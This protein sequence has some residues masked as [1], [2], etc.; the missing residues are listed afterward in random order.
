MARLAR[1]G[2]GKKV[3]TIA[4]LTAALTAAG[5]IVAAPASAG[6]S[7]PVG[8]HCVFYSDFSSAKHEYFV[9]DND[10][11]NDYFNKGGAS[12]KGSLVNNNVWA[13]SNST[14]TDYYSLYYYSPY[15]Y[16]GLVFCVQ[17]GSQ[18]SSSQLSSN[19]TPGDGVGQRDEASSVDIR[20]QGWIPGGCF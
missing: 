8:A 12:G 5:G 16:G 3:A 11:A 6:I 15:K 2:I 20:S 18:V 4:G 17:P 9:S 10:F 19:G 13:A 14:S 7:C 1:P